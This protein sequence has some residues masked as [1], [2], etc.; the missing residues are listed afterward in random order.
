MR[1]HAR[2]IRCSRCTQLHG[3]VKTCF[4]R[5]PAGATL[6]A[7]AAGNEPDGLTTRNRGTDC[8]KSPEMLLVSNA[9]KKMRDGYDRRRR[10]GAGMLLLQSLPHCMRPARGL[11]HTCEPR[12]RCQ[13]VARQLSIPRNVG[14]YGAR[15]AH[16]LMYIPL[17]G[18]FVPLQGPRAMSGA[19]AACCTSW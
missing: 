9:Q 6:L 4:A 19:W 10:E 8:V 14:W 5:L 2:A 11:R 16:T 3:S 1:T 13:A 15:S 18:T 17:T 7:W 12:C